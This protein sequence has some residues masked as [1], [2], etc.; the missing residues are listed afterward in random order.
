MAQAAARLRP[1]L[2]VQRVECGANPVPL[3]PLVQVSFAMNDDNGIPTGF[4]S[5]IDVCDSEFE[6]L[7]ELAHEDFFD[8]LGSP[9]WIE[10]IIGYLTI[11]DEPFAF[12][13][14]TYAE[15]VGN[16]AW[17]AVQMPFDTAHRLI[18]HLVDSGKWNEDM[19]TEG[20]GSMAKS[21]Q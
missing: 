8:G 12:K 2:P 3:M 17:N 16:R 13:R 1:S 5:K 14:G 6:T 10:N 15:W 7:V 19:C 4:V 9:I 21:E 18:R 11:A 20:W